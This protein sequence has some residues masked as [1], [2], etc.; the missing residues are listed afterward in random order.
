MK[1]TN[2][3]LLKSMGLKVGDRIKLQKDD[4]KYT[5]IDGSNYENFDK[6]IFVSYNKDSDEWNSVYDLTYIIDKEME[7]EILPKSKK[8]GDLK[9]DVD[10]K[11]EKCPLRYIMCEGCAEDS[12]YEV[13]E[14]T[15]KEDVFDKEIYDLLKTRLDKEVL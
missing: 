7:Y 4:K 15:T 10:I 13:L 6:Y 9:C 1:F 14:R 3:D 5:L 11:C 8:V 2:E 12:L